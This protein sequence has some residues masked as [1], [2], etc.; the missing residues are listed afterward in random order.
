[1]IWHL[2]YGDEPALA[3]HICEIH[4]TLG[5]LI[6]CADARPDGDCSHVQTRVCDCLMPR[7]CDLCEAYEEVA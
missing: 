4:R 3:G 1:M 7:A 6:H 5:R 2:Y